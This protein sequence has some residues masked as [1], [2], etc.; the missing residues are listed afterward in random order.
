MLLGAALR[1]Y[2]VLFTSGTGDLDGREDH[3]QQIRDG[4]A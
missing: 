2:C 4:G 1:A 3:A